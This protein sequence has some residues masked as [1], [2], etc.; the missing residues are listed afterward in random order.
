MPLFASSYP[1]AASCIF[2]RMLTRDRE[3]SACSLEIS[4]VNAH[5]YSRRGTKRKAVIRAVMRALITGGYSR[6]KL[7]QQ[8]ERGENCR[9][10]SPFRYIKRFNFVYRFKLHPRKN[11]YESG[12]FSF[13]SAG[14]ARKFSN[15]RFTSGL[16][17]LLAYLGNKLRPGLVRQ[18]ANIERRNDFMRRVFSIM[19]GK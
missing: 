6:A 5:R 9:V 16:I 2:P 15:A 1:R 10:A 11:I 19:S 17:F 8:I 4:R 3:F 13:M 12:S 7:G 18:A 14:C